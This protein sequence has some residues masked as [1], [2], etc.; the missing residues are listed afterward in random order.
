MDGTVKKQKMSSSLLLILC[1]LINMLSSFSTDIYLPALP[2]LCIDFG[3]TEV[4]ATSTITMFIVFYALG[5]L[6]G[7]PLCDKYGRKPILLLGGALFAVGSFC[8]IVAP[9]I[10]LLIVA[11][12]LAGAGAGVLTSDSFA[13]IHDCYEGE[14]GEKNIA[15]VQSI[16]SVG[17]VLAPV[18][19]AIVL[20]FT[21]WRMV[22]AVL[23]ALSVAIL[24]L[25]FIFEESLD[26]KDRLQGNIVD[27]LGRL[28]VVSKNKSVFFPLVI[29]A[30]S[31]L[32]FLGYVGVSS[33]IYVNHFGL[34]EQSY[35]IYYAL[36]ALM[37]IIG[38]MV[39]MKFWIGVNKNLMTKIC[40]GALLLC[41]I[42]TITIGVTSHYVFWAII[43]VFTFFTAILR[44]F[45]MNILFAQQSSDTG[46]VSA[47][48][49]CLN[50]ILGSVGMTVMTMGTGNLV[51]HFGL[52]LTVI[53]G[54][55]L[56]MWLA[57]MKSK[58]PCNGVK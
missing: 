28:L 26:E 39:Y 27:T 5:T 38:P 46:S 51:I 6:I 9:T 4:T 8:C 57:L 49:N 21:S 50:F 25:S 36:A 53:A 55:E 58:I 45:S 43:V 48:Y 17:P 29:F 33:Y 1:I 41:G 18:I 37:A 10:T 52:V 42:A 22:F 7:G 30:L 32:T 11:R 13:I 14:T 54:A 35:S 2:E 34:T 47:L 12:M 44:P 20:T 31:S 23:A 19:G 24:A 16:A 15:L 56:I 3:V 40:L